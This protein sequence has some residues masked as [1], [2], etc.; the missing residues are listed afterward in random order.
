MQHVGYALVDAQGNELQSWGGLQYGVT[1][2]VPPMIKLP[3]GDDVHCP[4][5]GQIGNWQLLERWLVDD[6][7]TYSDLVRHDVA[8]E[9]GKVVVRAVY[10]AR[11]LAAVKAAVKASI[12]AAAETARHKYIT[13]GSGK[14]MSY[15]EVAAEAKRHVATGGAGEYPFLAARVASGRYPDIATAVTATLALEAAWTAVGAAI[16]EIEDRAKLAIDAATTVDQ[17]RAAEQAT[18]P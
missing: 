4:S 14:A 3:N 11:D 8:V 16:D 18:W 10:A 5:L 17:V 6:R 12:S 15:Q 1:A 13:P 7:P 9:N 2:G